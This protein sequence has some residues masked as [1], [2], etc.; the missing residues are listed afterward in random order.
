MTI[1]EL[2]GFALG[3][4]RLSY[5]DFCRCTPEEFG[6]ICKA[7]QDQREVDYKDRWERMRMLATIAI[8][9]HLKHKITSK[10]LLPFPWEEKGKKKAEAPKVSAEEARK[11][12]ER[13]VSR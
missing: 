1:T 6:S 11:R 7:Y 8:Q 10:K 3:C 2:L 9:P 4:V 13:L 5:D 12:F